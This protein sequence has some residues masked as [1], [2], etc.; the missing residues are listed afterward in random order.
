MTVALQST[1]DKR[2]VRSVFKSPQK[3][4]DVHPTRAGDLD[5]LERSWILDPKAPSEVSS[6][7]STMGTAECHHLGLEIRHDQLSPFINK[8][9]S[10][11]IT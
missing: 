2:P 9:S 1:G 5:D 6:V 10:L 8:A 3:V 11:T 4:Q 7:V